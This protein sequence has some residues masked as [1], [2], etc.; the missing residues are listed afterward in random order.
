[1]KALVIGGSGILLGLL[2]ITWGHIFL[3][4]H[5]LLI[6][7]YI[8]LCLLTTYSGKKFHCHISMIYVIV[9]K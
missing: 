2:E 7:G 4:P 1:M 5:Y 3:T 6:L 8:I 9:F